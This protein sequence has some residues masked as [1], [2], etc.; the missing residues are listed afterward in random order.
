MRQAMVWGMVAALVGTAP[1][2]VWASP[3]GADV[4]TGVDAWAKGDYRTA[5][6]E[7]RGPAVAGDADAQ[8]NLGQAYKLGRGVPVDPALAESWFRK[9]A[10]QKHP[11]AEDNYGLALYQSG[12]KADAVPWLEKSVARGEPR[13]QLVLGTMLF[14]GDGVPRDVP[15]A[16]ALMTRA[17][18][19]GLKSASET[20]AQMD[21]YISPADREKGTA[22]AQ[23]YAAEQ[24]A[25]ADAVV[26]RTVVGSD[27]PRPVQAAAASAP[28][29]R[30]RKPAT[31]PPVEKEAPVVAAARVE[32]LVPAPKPVLAKPTPAKLVA[33]PVPKAAPATTGRYRVQ[34]GA[35]KD[36]SNARELWARVGGKIGGTPSFTKAGAF[37][38]LVGGAFASAADAQ[39]ACRVAGVSCIVTR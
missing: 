24:Q 10:L 25:V 26:G 8:F 28:A 37:T 18:G 21:G 33:K 39:R 22:L 27:A 11:Q 7:W 35:F 4:K 31:K 6:E 23:R 14:N 9:A 5:V 3:A 30:G 13:T 36:A 2:L 32:R 19:A 15:R 16:Y 12:R 38:R 17:S 20:L 34:L 29:P 1:A